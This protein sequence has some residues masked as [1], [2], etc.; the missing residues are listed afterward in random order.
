VKNTSDF[1]QSGKGR[2]KVLPFG[3][4]FYERRKRKIPD[5]YVPAAETEKNCGNA[6]AFRKTGKCGSLHSLFGSFLLLSLAL[7]HHPICVFE[8]PQFPCSNCAG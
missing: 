2:K 3:I 4:F 1:S 6:R 7:E 8:T 5:R